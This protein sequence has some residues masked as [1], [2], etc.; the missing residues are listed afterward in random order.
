MLSRLLLRGGASLSRHASVFRGAS[1]F[2]TATGA[3]KSSAAP[4][5]GSGSWINTDHATSIIRFHNPSGVEH[6]GL[7]DI[8]EREARVARPNAEGKMTIPADAKRETIEVILPPVDPPAIFCIG[9]NYEDHAREVKM[10][11]PRLVCVIG[12]GLSLSFFLPPRKTDDAA[13]RVSVWARPKHRMGAWDRSRNHCIALLSQHLAKISFSS[14]AHVS[15]ALQPI[16]FTKTTNTLIGHNSACVE[17]FSPVFCCIRP[18]NVAQRER[19][20]RR[21]L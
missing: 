1:G 12:Y 3:L 5:S 15:L 8:F 11:V 19:E 18:A 16:V 9:L 13:A 10:E 20:G 14:M 7:T 21:K 4:T 6:F 2:A 17:M